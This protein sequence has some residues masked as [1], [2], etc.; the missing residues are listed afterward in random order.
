VG[1]DVSLARAA[2]KPM[3]IENTSDIFMKDRG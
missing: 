1:D 3:S 2:D